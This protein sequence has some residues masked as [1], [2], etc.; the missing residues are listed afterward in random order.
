MARGHSRNRRVMSFEYP[1]WQ[2]PL[3]A[4][5][6]E[7]NPEQWRGKLE[8]AEEAVARR[9]QELRLA[10]NNEHELRSLF[11]PLA[12]VRGVK[13]DRLESAKFQE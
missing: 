5:I 4:V 2:G 12:I 7:F 3:A 13:R 1:S 9:I 10:E 11:D 6:L 8:K